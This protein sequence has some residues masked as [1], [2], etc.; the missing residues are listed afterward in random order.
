MDAVPRNCYIR[1]GL[2]LPF[3]VILSH[4]NEE[5]AKFLSLYPE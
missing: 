3:D 5:L 2:I 1:D 4:P